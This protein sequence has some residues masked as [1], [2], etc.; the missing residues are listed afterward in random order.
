MQQIFQQLFPVLI[1]SLV[2][3]VE[4]LEDSLKLLS[5]GKKSKFHINKN[6]III[7]MKHIKLLILFITF[8]KF[9]ILIFYTL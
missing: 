2:S 1:K 9:I 6:L 3:F 5:D 7:S 4:E 8:R